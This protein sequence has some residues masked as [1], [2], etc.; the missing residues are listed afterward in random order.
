MCPA[1]HTANAG[2]CAPCVRPFPPSCPHRLGPT[3]RPARDRSAVASV[4]GLRLV[5]DSSHCNWPLDLT[6]RDRLM[7]NLTDS[8]GS[9]K[10]GGCTPERR[11]S[12]QC[13]VHLGN[14]GSRRTGRC[15]DAGLRGLQSKA[16]AREGRHPH[17]GTRRRSDAAFTRSALPS[18]SWVA[19]ARNGSGMRMGH[20]PVRVQRTR[21]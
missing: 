18:R 13:A 3:T 9:S 11:G 19:A 1:Y 6:A 5:L 21:S 10:V 2:V 17:P 8:P 16:A 7:R 4:S 20:T 15:I 12:R 14:G